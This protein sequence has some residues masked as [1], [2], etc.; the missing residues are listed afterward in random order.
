MTDIT[1][2]SFLNQAQ[3]PQTAATAAAAA[4]TPSSTQSKMLGKDDFLKLL[5]AEL[6][7]QDPSKPMDDSQTIAQMAQFSALEATQQLEATIQQAT[8]V[9]S[10]FQAGALI[11]KYVQ[12][13][14]ADGSDVV[15]PVTGVDFTSTNGV[16][17]PTVV[18]N[19]TDLD[20]STIVRVSSTP[21]TSNSS[22]QPNT[23]NSTTGSPVT[24]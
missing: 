15:G 13:N 1:P 12:A 21:I 23:G 16:M 3:V 18:V 4:S 10:L 7:N 22:S 6:Q 17:T 9:Q 14:Q 11:G 2:S 19:G 5:V 8:N 24:N 20:Y